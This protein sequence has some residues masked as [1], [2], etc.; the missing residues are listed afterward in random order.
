[1]P[2]PPLLLALQEI[3][4]RQEQTC[5]LSPAGTWHHNEP[6]HTQAKAAVQQG[7]TSNLHMAPCSSQQGERRSLRKAHWHAWHA[8]QS[9]QRQK[10]QPIV[11]AQAGYRS[12]SFLGA[13]RFN[14]LP[15]SLRT[16]HIPNSF[17]QELNNFI[18]IGHPVRRP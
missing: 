8:C 12:I 15:E 14:A 10:A 4:A 17:R 5:S 7:D 3:Q 9:H 2:R 18:N 6:G 1:M 11:Q 13:D 16:N